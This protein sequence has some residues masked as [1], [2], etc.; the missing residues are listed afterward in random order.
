MT[1]LYIDSAAPSEWAAALDSAL[2]RR[3]TCNPL[4]M[5]AFI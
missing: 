2:L 1:Q 3:A 5:R 4:L